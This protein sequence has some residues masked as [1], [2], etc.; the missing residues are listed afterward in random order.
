MR[1]PS[2]LDKLQILVVPLLLVAERCLAECQE[3]KPVEQSDVGGRHLL[4]AHH[5]PAVHSRGL[6][7]LVV[8]HIHPRTPRAVPY[9]FKELPLLQ[10]KVVLIFIEM[11][12]RVAHLRHRLGKSRLGRVVDV[13]RDVARHEEGS[14]R[15]TQLRLSR[16]LRAEQIQNGER[17]CHRCHNVLEQRREQEAKRH[18]GVV[19]EHGDEFL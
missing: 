10:I 3:H 2:L 6:A 14:Q 12:H 8:V 4:T 13:R 1:K 19:P 16:A 15:M 7:P 9:S 11:H 18:L 17:C 5:N